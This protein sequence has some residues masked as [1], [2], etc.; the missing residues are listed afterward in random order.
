MTRP[1]RTFHPLREL[2]SSRVR[3]FFRE[4]EAI[5]WVYLF[6]VLLAVALGI[7]FRAKPVEKVRVVVEEGPVAAT[8][9]ALD[10]REAAAR[11]TRD[12]RFTVTVKPR[13]E[14]VS[15]FTRGR[16]DL[17][18]RT[19]GGVRLVFDRTRP[20]S[21]L[22]KV[23]AGDAL[24]RPGRSDP[25][26]IGEEALTAPGSRYIDFLIPGLIGMNIMGGGLWGVGFVIVDMRVRKLLKR[27]VATPMRRSDFLLS[28]MGSRLFFLIPEVIL[29]LLV[30]WIGFG[31]PFRGSILALAAIVLVSALC[32]CGMG[33]LAATRAKKIET[34]SGIMNLIMLPMWILSGIFFS[35]ERFPEVFQPLIHALPLTA[36]ID[37]LRAVMLEGHTLS[38]QG[39]QLFILAA[40]GAASFAVSLK[41]FRWS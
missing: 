7:A 33:L 40:W 25:I 21:E 5:F 24:E 12:P 28:M 32:F 22:A 37:A 18:V 41:L 3:E 20:E 34:I 10:A 29:L 36:S 31:V 13:D 30:G 4:P 6:P 11:L 8:A 35:S 23:L 27:F 1:A 15:D 26:P 9:G 38:S 17:V 39:G 2:I 16:V 19:D 14:A